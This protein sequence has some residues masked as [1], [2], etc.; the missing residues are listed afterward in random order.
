MYPTKYYSKQLCWQKSILLSELSSNWLVPNQ[1]ALKNAYLVK[2]KHLQV[3]HPMY[4]CQTIH[5]LSSQISLA[6]RFNDKEVAHNTTIDAKMGADDVY[7][8]TAIANLKKNE[9]DDES[10]VVCLVKIANTNYEKKATV[11]YDG[12]EKYSF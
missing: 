7:D 9:V 4:Q 3:D 8:I 10:N 1:A 11:L 6:F 5:Q 2:H 12:M